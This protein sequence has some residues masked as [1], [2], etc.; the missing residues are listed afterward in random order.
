ME[1]YGRNDWRDYLTHGWGHSPKQKAREK[2]YNHEYYLKNKDKHISD[3]QF[4]RYATAKG[5]DKDGWNKENDVIYRKGDRGT[6]GVQYVTLPGKLHSYAPS[7]Y[8]VG[9]VARYKM[10]SQ[11]SYARNRRSYKQEE[12]TERRRNAV[13][14]IGRDVLDDMLQ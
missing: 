7:S 12:D 8:R 3:R 2:E 14:R 4:N 13:A 11:M 1:Y 10:G 6:D 9:N 5:M